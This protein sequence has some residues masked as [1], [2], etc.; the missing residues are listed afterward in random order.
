MFW[1][2]IKLSFPSRWSVA[3]VVWLIF[4]VSKFRSNST[5]DVITV[6]GKISTDVALIGSTDVALIGS[7][8]VALIGSTVTVFDSKLL[9]ASSIIP[10]NENSSAYAVPQ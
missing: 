7:T 1:I 2:V 4:S 3:G 9:L 10:L 6:D 8:D 5:S